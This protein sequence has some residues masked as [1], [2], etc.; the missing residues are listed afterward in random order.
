MEQFGILP[1]RGGTTEKAGVAAV[2]LRAPVLVLARTATP[3]L[4]LKALAL[5]AQGNRAPTDFRKAVLGCA[6]RLL[7]RAP[8]PRCHEHA[9]EALLELGQNLH[10]GV[11]R[12][13]G[14]RRG[15]HRHQAN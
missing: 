2:A 5:S 15:R 7:F 6:R 11:R 9:A 14:S 10:G 4:A 3:A 13:G 12:L 8:L 1:V